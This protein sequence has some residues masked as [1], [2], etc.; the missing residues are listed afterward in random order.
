MIDEPE[1]TLPEQELVRYDSIDAVP[2]AEIRRIILE[3]LTRFG[4]TEVGDLLKR[5]NREL[6]FRR[7]GTRIQAR[8]ESI[9]NLLIREIRVVKASEDSRLRVVESQRS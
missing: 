4:G 3:I 2:E 9:V 5:V 8:I 6:G 7:L 1:V